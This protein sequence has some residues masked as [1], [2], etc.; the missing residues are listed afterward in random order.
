MKLKALT[1][2]VFCKF[3]KLQNE[4]NL[5][6]KYVPFKNL[7]ESN[8]KDK[9][10]IKNFSTPNI[11][12]T[13]N[14]PINI[15]VQDSFDGSVNLIINDD[16]NNPVMIN[17]R[18]SPQEESTF[19]I[20]DHKGN[21][22]TNL[23]EESNLK[24][25][26]SL[27][28]TINQIPKLEFQG[29]LKD[30]NLK[31]GAY[32]FYFKLSDNDGNETDFIL[33]SGLVVCH[34]GE[35]NSPNSIRM[36][37]ANENSQK[38]VVFN[39]T[40]LDNSY[41]YI[42]VYY[43][44]TTSDESGIDVTQAFCIDEKYS[45]K[46]NTKLIITGYENQFEIS[47][48][49]LNPY[50]QYCQ[51]VKT[52]AQCQNMLF[53]GNIAK[54]EIDH[55]FFEKVSLLFKS[56]V[57]ESKEHLGT[58]NTNYKDPFDTYGYYNAKN[59][60]YNLGYFPT[61]Y[62]R[63]G[64]VYILKDWSLSP[65][66]NIRGCI[67][68]KNV[69]NIDWTDLKDL[70]TNDE[71]LN[72]KSSIYE[73]SKGV[74]KFPNFSVFDSNGCIKPRG[75]SIKFEYDSSLDGKYKNEKDYKELLKEKINGFFFVRQNRI[76]TFYAQGLVIGKTKNDYG[77]LPVIKKDAYFVA[78][79]FLSKASL[80]QY[81]GENSKDIQGNIL[82]NEYV[83]INDSNVENK[84]IIFPEVQVRQ[85]IFNTLFT[86]EE[87]KVE[88]YLTLKDNSQIDF[89]N[90]KHVYADIRNY[91]QS[92]STIFTEKLTIV[93]DSL[94]VTTNGED[95]FS[96]KAGEEGEVLQV[97]DVTFNPNTTSGQGEG[98]ENK[99]LTESNYKIRG[100]FGLYVGTNL[101]VHEYGTI[102]NVRPKDYDPKNPQYI[103]NQFVLRSNTQEP[104][105]A[106]S[107]RLETGNLGEEIHCFRG[108]CFIN[109]VTHRLHRNFIDNELPLNDNIVDP[110]TWYNNYV[111]VQKSDIVNVDG[112]QFVVNK[113]SVSFYRKWTVIDNVIYTDHSTFKETTSVIDTTVEDISGDKVW[114][115][116]GSVKINKG[117]LNAVPLG[118]WV[119]F[120][121]LS[122]VNL[123]M[124]DVDMSI[125]GEASL[126]NKPRGFYPL[127]PMSKLS[128]NKQPESSVING[129]I[130]V[131]LSKRYNNIQLD[132]PWIKNKFDTRIMYSD[133]A[134]T[135]AFKNGYRVF[136]GQNYRDYPKTYG[137]IVSLKELNGDLIAVMEH[138]V[139]RIPVNERAVA[140]Q[141]SG[142][143]VYINTSNV[144]PLNPL[145]ISDSLGSLWQ[146]SV[147][148]TTGLEGQSLIYGVDT[149]AKKIWVTDGQ[150][151]K[152][153]SDFKVQKFLNDNINFITTDKQEI[154]GEKNCKTHYNSFKRDVIFTFYNKDKEWSLC[155][156][157]TLQRFITFYTWTPVFSANIDNIYFSFDKE[158]YS[159]GEYDNSLW[160]HGQAGNYEN[161]EIIKPTNWYGKTHTFE[162][163][164][165]VNNPTI[166][167]KIFNNLKI[168]SN[169]TAPKEF[170][171]EIIGEAYDWF[172]YK[173]IIT[174]INKNYEND[175][176]VGYKEVL[177]NTLEG[178]KNKYSD[179]PIGEFDPNIKFKKLPFIKRFKSS[180]L[181]K[182]EANTTDVI[183]VED[184][185][186]NEDRIST[187][188]Y[189]NDIKKVGRI[190]G[191]M[192][193]LED[194]WDIEI[195]PTNFKDAY[196]DK[197]GNLQ[198][199]SLKQER[200]RD[201][202]IKIRVIYSGEDLAVIQGLKTFYT[203]SYA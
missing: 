154:V 173:D 124:R 53:F 110:L 203:I 112:K 69:D 95:Y 49:E 180:D 34:V 57:C 161:Q 22:D 43:S 107:D 70:V 12:Y 97:V 185:L 65:V 85:P 198:F 6:N 56:N 93:P 64:I 11:Q 182:W 195:R 47:I 99:A 9:N 50:Y 149:V 92:N 108:D 157:E 66:F 46:N 1:T 68:D 118:T 150:S 167:Q 131:T 33:E 55:E 25:E 28:K 186:L 130:N 75:L 45:I 159:K 44:R 193:Y 100:N 116:F 86:S 27:Y 151:I 143:N 16:N 129:A 191:N 81:L 192:Q 201:K 102:V 60:Y 8:D 106:I 73:N 165:I 171:Y 104:Y 84:A 137:S 199:K 142:G 177:S 113:P 200:I 61:E 19:I 3:K 37:I 90:N 144:L 98:K 42:K 176:T 82:H 29:L 74:F 135:D 132:I 10:K 79:S 23:Y 119:T 121:C 196:L 146:D 163:E 87:Y 136:Q 126:F 155:Y 88:E 38:A 94:K 4:G 120:T 31:C 36:G 190:K 26:V 122:N 63:F 162:Y 24:Q 76:P 189:G 40:N 41:D 52:Q 2:N 141:G 145:V 48:D 58:L 202:Y 169:K 138:G 115:N 152:I 133:I 134:V 164:F 179:F 18:F 62:Y 77:N 59:L 168:I 187:K 170:V 35:I 147:I 188:Q 183:L 111:V 15:E 174:W 54:P 148:K 123:A 72:T 105:F 67:L 5:V 39:L 83:K 140:A 78:E 21:K 7:I 32:H 89:I 14:Y 114:E 194:L 153:L 197:Q 158:N 101:D 184:D 109:Q 96:A 178:L 172:K 71:G 175:I 127:Q 166:V 17:S 91:K 160:K 13:K 20:T 80:K 103:E 128:S 156:N 51:T 125:P 30:G 139:L 117:D 181:T